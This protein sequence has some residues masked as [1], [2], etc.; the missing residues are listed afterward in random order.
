MLVVALGFAFRCLVF[1]AEVATAALVAAKRVV[2]DELTHRDEVVETESL[3]KLDVHALFVAG[4]EEVGLESLADLFELLKREL[5]T[6]FV[7]SHAD[8]FPHYVSEL[9]VDRIH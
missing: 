5:Q 6:L 2:G 3:V 9:L 7:A 8:I 1:R 4:D